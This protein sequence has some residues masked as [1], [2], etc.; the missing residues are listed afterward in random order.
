M[1]FIDESIIEVQAGNGGNGVASF[2]REKYIPKGGPNGGD[3]GRGGHVYVV[4][5]KNLNTLVDYRFKHFHSAS[6]GESGKSKDQYGKAGSDI[7]LRVPIGTILSDVES[8]KVI[9]DLSSDNQELLLAR[10][11]RGGL[12]NLHFKSSTNRAPRKYTKGS[13][14]DNLKIKLVLKI[15]ADVGLVGL[16]NA[17]KSTFTRAVSAATP[18]VGDYPFTTLEPNL[19]TVRIDYGRH[20]VLA[21][22]PGI[23]KGASAGAGLGLQFLRHLERTKLILHLVETSPM[24]K[25][26][27][28]L[29]RIEDVSRELE[30]HSSALKEIPRWL[31]VNKIDLVDTTIRDEIMQMLEKY[32]TSEYSK[33]SFISA[34][35]KIG[36]R[37]LSLNIMNHLDNNKVKSNV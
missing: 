35:N 9:A 13:K 30:A 21:D 6:N 11:G 20:F 27:D 32:L 1:K 4:S 29:S 24:M 3:G 14:G 12:G 7:Y 25:S 34:I 22:V 23:I 10:G 16:P 36:C 18:R 5:D 15:L 17:G 26:T 28:L 37:E 31:V 33:I 8:G 2:R 19:G